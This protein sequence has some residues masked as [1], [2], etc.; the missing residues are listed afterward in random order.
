[1]SKHERA[2]GMVRQ[3]AE[4][5]RCRVRY[6]QGLVELGQYPPSGDNGVKTADAWEHALR[7]LEAVEGVEEWMPYYVEN[8]IAT[9]IGQPA[10][11][12]KLKGTLQAI[13][14]AKGGSHEETE[15]IS[16]GEEEG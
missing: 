3:Q 16:D 2:V 1:M 11:L 9:R 6:L 8:I 7:V 15:E 10:G 14:D 5:F 12:L 13:L 4:H